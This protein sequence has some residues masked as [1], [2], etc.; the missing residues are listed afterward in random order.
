MAGTKTKPTGASVDAYL[1]SRASPE[2]LGDCKALMAMFKRIT[3]QPATMW[4]PS[5]VG[6]GSYSYRYESGHTGACALAGFAV[7]GRDLVVYLLAENSDQRALLS[8]L[9]KHKMGKSC[10]YF[11]RLADLDAKVLESLV[12][13]AIAETKRRHTVHSGA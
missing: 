7:R 1:T 6:Y 4:G 2:Q 11:Q 13:G 10:L 12:I 8:K 5:I 9:G 3:K